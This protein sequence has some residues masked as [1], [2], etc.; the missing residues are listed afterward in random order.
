MNCPHCGIAFH[1]S[2]KSTNVSDVDGE[3]RRLWTTQVTK[4]PACKNDTI[5]L[6][7]RTW[8]SGQSHVISFFV[9]Y[10]KATN[11]KSTPK[12]VPDDIKE[13]YE[14]AC[15]VLADSEKA[16]AALSRRCLQAI[17]RGQG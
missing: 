16:S 11:R 8:V 9:V 2:W 14:A 7:R 3:D 15:R 6:E 17:L 4:C 1:E 10:P 13:D 5:V 12:E